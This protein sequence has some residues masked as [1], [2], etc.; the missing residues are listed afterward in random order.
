MSSGRT[1]GIA[2]AALAGFAA[3]VYLGLFVVLA[4]VNWR[5]SFET[6]IV[7]ATVGLGTLVA[8]GAAVLA[9]PDSSRMWRLMAVGASSV[10]LVSAIILVLVEADPVQLVVVGVVEVGA[11]TV[12]AG[13]AVR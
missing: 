8:V 1:V 13:R 2:A 9:A 5:R 7:L 11:V 4:T 10:G 6:Q 12:A 3:G